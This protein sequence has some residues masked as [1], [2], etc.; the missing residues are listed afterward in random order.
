MKEN[1]RIIHVLIVVSLLF[2]SL[3]GYMT[4][5]QIF[6]SPGLED[7]AYNRRRQAAEEDI[8]R[9]S[10][11]D[12]NGTV[13]A[14]SSINGGKQQRIYPYK[15]LYSQ[16]I[17]YNSKV[18]GRSL[19]EQT[20]NSYLLGM[21]EYS[22]VLNVFNKSGKEKETGSSLHLTLDHSIQLLG[23]KL[24]G[25]RKGAVVA[26][27]PKTGE[28]L[29][30]VSK[31]G[32]DP[33]ESSL[34]S[35]WKGMVESKDSPFLPRATQGLYVP[36]STYKVLISALALENGL[37]KDKFK[38]SGTVT[39]DGKKISNYGGKAYG[40]IGIAEGLKV[41]SN[42]VYSQ[43]GVKL[44]ED[45]LKDMA[46]RVGMGKDIAFDIPVSKSL[47]QYGVMGKNDLAAVGMGQGKIMVSPLHMAMIT[48]SIANKGVMMKPALVSRVEAP[49]GT[50]IKN[51]K[52]TALYRVM[53]A[54]I[55]DKVG[56]MMQDVVDSGTG[57]KA[58]I[59]GIEVAGKTGTAENELSGKQKNKE[60]SWFIGFAPVEDPQIAVAVVI[61]Y[62]GYSGGA[63]AAPIAQKIMSEYLK[64]K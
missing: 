51:T 56:I 45:N 60:H 61:E 40:D 44:G 4:Y 46:E 58:A 52:P 30:L 47:F 17:G 19:L 23:D 54:D 38:D 27:D 49:N 63:I 31:P 12:R 1:S 50:N 15:A 7:S 20:Y 25:D 8:T 43:L 21:D 55:A 32:Y 3:V 6:M 26:M 36:G 29:A 13:L 11:Y 24:L 35:S 39:I 14:K 41:S 18:Y 10:I 2:F 37:D 16:V 28:I 62:G 59:K 53:E 57:T 22:R 5:F 9:G 33:S 34:A 42:V 48:S 64:T